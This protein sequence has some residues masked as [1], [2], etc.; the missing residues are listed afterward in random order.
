M[1]RKSDER[2]KKIA[3][4]R[5]EQAIDRKRRGRPKSIW[6]NRGFLEKGENKLLKMRDNGGDG[7]TWERGR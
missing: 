7:T 6:R 3:F 1:L 4:Y 2:L 5:A